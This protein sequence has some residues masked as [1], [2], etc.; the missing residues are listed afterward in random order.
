[1]STGIS[2]KEVLLL[3]MLLLHIAAKYPLFLN[4]IS[5]SLPALSTAV[6]LIMRLASETQTFPPMSVSTD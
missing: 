6:A 2:R 5:N 1:M 3:V 4:S